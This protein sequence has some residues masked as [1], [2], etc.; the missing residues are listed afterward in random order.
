[1]S[2]SEAISKEFGPAACL[3]GCS[4]EPDC[5]NLAEIYI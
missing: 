4:V 2:L 3:A 5:K 1:M